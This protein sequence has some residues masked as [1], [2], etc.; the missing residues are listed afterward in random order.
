MPPSQTIP[1]SFVPKAPA[2]ERRS[3]RFDSGGVF[4]FLCYAA[5]F[6]TIILSIG[7]F[8]YKIYLEQTLKSDEEQLQ[9]MRGDAMQGLAQDF[10]RLDRQ[11]TMG[12]Q[13][14]DKH[15]SASRFLSIFSDALPT[16]VQLTS[17]QATVNDDGRITLTG[18][19]IAKSFNTLAVASAQ[20]AAGH[21]VSAIFSKLVVGKDNAVS[22]NITAAV[23]PDA[24][25][26]QVPVESPSE[27]VNE[28]TP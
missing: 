7:V 26:F 1:T 27:T 4:G 23:T 16:G 12:R 3:P 25:S 10:I 21:Q 17:L 20:F 13:L 24:F 22:F 15:I 11:L 18:A 5:L 14:L 9:K 6:I 28:Q 2:S 8:S 19:G